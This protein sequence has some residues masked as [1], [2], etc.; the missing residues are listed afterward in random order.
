MKFSPKVMEIIK[1]I[2]NQN[3]YQE[4]NDKIEYL[5]KQEAKLLVRTYAY[6][7][8]KN[9]FIEIELSAKGNAYSMLQN[10]NLNGFCWNA[11]SSI[12]PFFKDE[13]EILRGVIHPSTT[14]EI[15]HAWI[16][17]S[18][19]Q[20]EYVFD[21]ALNIIVPKELYNDTFQTEING[22][23]CS[24]KVRDTYIEILSQYNFWKKEYQEMPIGDIYSPFYLD[25]LSAKGLV[26]KQ[27]VK[28]LSVYYDRGW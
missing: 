5:E 11:T 13:D 21:P 27:K 24:K 17:F 8:L 16:R 28:R 1:N 18:F 6:Y 22:S 9:L 7:L 10:K 15:E 26:T 3:Q 20:R 23:V 4:E 14:R 2:D 12:I 19:L 25:T